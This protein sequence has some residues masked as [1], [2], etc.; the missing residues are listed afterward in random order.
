MDSERIFG[1]FHCPV[2]LLAPL[3]IASEGAKVLSASLKK[4]SNSLY[5]RNHLL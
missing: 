1:M 2:L 5:D 3:K 4:C